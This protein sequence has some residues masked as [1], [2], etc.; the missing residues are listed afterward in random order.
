MKDVA[1]AIDHLVGVFQDPIIVW[2]SPWQADIPQHLKDRVP[3]ARL[4]REMEVLRGGEDLATDV[5]AL[6]YMMP[7]T[8]EHPV[9]WE[10]T[11]I[12]L[13][14]GTKVMGTD[15][16]PEDI[17][18]EKLNDDQQRQLLELKRWIRKQQREA[19]VQRGREE[20]KR[21]RE[22]EAARRKE[23]QPALFEF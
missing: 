13:Y 1:E 16:M 10:W 15:K 17:K 4:V 8:L 18:V 5:E 2:P 23:E 20:K 22:E 11:Q 6:I 9:D 7:L 19:T 21:I 14:L 12:Y 3:L